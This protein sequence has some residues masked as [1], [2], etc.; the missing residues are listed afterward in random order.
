MDYK[1]YNE[2]PKILINPKGLIPD[3]RFRYLRKS[4]A[5]VENSLGKFAISF[6]GGK[7]IFP[8]GKSESGE[9]PLETVKREL[10]EEMGIDFELSDFSKLFE[11]ETIYDNYFDYRI[12]TFG[13]RHTITTYFY[14]KTNYGI[15]NNK[16]SLTEGEKSQNFQISFV[17]KSELLKLITSDHSK[18][19]NGK[20]FDAENK[21]VIENFFNNL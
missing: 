21:I 18:F 13:F 7:C 2:P 16:I 3:E 8:G 19:E 9:T 17:N 14:V 11:L 12:G 15:Q 5:I 6:E 20:Y 4:R 1:A 10:K